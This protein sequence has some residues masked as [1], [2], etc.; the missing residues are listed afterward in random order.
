MRAPR[1]RLLEAMLEA[2]GELGYERARVQDALE[3]AGVARATFY[4][5]FADKEDCFAQAYGEAAEWLY[6][7]LVG[8]AREQPGWRE[9]LRAALAE[10]VAFCAARP[11]IARAL[12][13]EPQAAGGRALE[14]HDRLAERL[15]EAL[16]EGAPEAAQHAARPAITA[17]FVIGAIET[18]L[19][20]RLM[21]GKAER[22]PEMLPGLIHFAVMQYCG[23]EAAWEEMTAAPRSSWSSQRRA[24]TRPPGKG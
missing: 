4:A 20:S 24:A 3:R 22:A 1:E 10:L 12:I 17:P 21:A 13:L 9:G 19:R 6:E 23:E 14:Q 15:A 8:V 16:D 18:L 2:A 11:A 7:R 5:H